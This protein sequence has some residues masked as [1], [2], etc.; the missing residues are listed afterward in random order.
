MIITSVSMSRGFEQEKKGTSN[1]M[2]TKNLKLRIGD[3]A[4]DC[5]FAGPGR[6]GQV[7]RTP[8][9]SLI[10]QQGKSYRLLRFRRNS[11]V[12]TPQQ[13]HPQR[14]ELVGEHSHQGYIARAP[15]GDDHLSHFRPR[16][17]EA[18]HR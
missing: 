18:P 11:K 4:Q 3:L 10:G 1:A 7:T 6:G 5:W 12:V 14:P 8:I 17:K 16:G 13:A 9:P 15:A 2:R